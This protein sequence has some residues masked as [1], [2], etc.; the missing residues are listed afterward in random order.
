VIGIGC[1]IIIV[2]CGLILLPPMIYPPLSEA[3]LHAVSDADTRIQLQQAQSQLQNNVRLAILQMAAGLLVVVGAAATWRQVQVN[4]EGQITER[5]TRAV[6]QIGSDNVDVRIGGIYAL[7]RM[8]EILR[9][10]GTPSSS[11]WVHLCATTPFGT[12]AQPMAR[13]TQPQRSR[14]DPGCRYWLQTSKQQSVFW[15]DVSRTPAGGRSS[16]LLLKQNSICPELI[17]VACSFTEAD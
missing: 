1:L 3:D 5:F 10:R 8:P 2:A 13:N 9:R 15:R 11:S 14:S 4:R 6:E 7:E 17:F 16:H 12:L